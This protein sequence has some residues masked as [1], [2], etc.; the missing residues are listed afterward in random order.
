MP[1]KY[2][3]P[4]YPGE[5]LHI[6]NNEFQVNTITVGNF[7]DGLRKNQRFFTLATLLSNKLNPHKLMDHVITF[8]FNQI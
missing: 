3:S 8:E 5:I 4:N 1:T 7:R 2:D 6:V